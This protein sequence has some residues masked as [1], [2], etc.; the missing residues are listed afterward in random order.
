MNQVSSSA[1][2]ILGLVLLSVLASIGLIL[3]VDMPTGALFF[4]GYLIIATVSGIFKNKGCSSP[5]AV[6]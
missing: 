2:I 3:L 6:S 1:V 4:M 5:R